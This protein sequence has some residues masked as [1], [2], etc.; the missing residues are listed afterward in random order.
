MYRFAKFDRECMVSDIVV[1]QAT[2][3]DTYP[4]TDIHCANVSG[5]VFTRRNSD[6]TRTPTPYEELTLFERYLNGGPWMSVETCAVWLAYLLR[7]GDEIPLIAEL[8][9]HVMGEAEVTIGYEPAPYGHHLHITTLKIHPDAPDPQAIAAALLTYVQQM[10]SVMRF[11][12]VTTV[13][14]GDWFAS[15]DFK[16]LIGRREVALSTKEG[17]IVY[18]AT[19]LP[20]YLPEQIKGWYM[21]FGREHNARH[22]WAHIWPGF[23]NAVPELVE[24]EVARFQFELSGQV[25]ICLLR[26][27]RY[28]PDQAHVYLWTQRALSPHM[29]SAVRDRAARQGYN[30]IALFVDDQT[31][32][33]VEA[34]AQESGA[35]SVIASLRV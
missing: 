8:D 22:E 30:S 25:G 5:G 21:P 27:N 23:W 35:P 9:G 32:A 11:Q 15:H 33:M 6:G 20:S 3:A 14:P 26:Q 28:S 2:L 10:A 7:Y 12:Q 13:D 31:R 24:P 4:I 17:R 16:P 19:N 29:I 34:E 1:R 18:K